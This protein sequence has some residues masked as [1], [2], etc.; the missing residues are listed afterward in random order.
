MKGFVQGAERQQTTLLPERLDDW[1]DESNPVRAVDV[2]VEALELR[3]L[4]F[5]GVTPAATGRPGYHPSPMLKLYIYGYLNRVQSS[6]RLERE[7]GRSWLH[8]IKYDGY[9][10]RVE[11]DGDRVRLITRGG[12]NWRQS[13][14]RPAYPPFL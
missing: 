2:F 10:L 14:G 3:E 9:R 8:E 6:R 5:D 1:V 4:G 11:R 12:Y 13:F 7:A